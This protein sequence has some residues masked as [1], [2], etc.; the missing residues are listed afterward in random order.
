MARDFDPKRLVVNPECLN[1]WVILSIKKL[2][3]TTFEVR[4]IPK[5]VPPFQ[6]A[7]EDETAA[8]LSR[9]TDDHDYQYR[10]NVCIFYIEP[11]T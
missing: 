7:L 8:H 3:D 6:C 11:Q 4:A 9:E 1:H 2:P 5:Y 10:P